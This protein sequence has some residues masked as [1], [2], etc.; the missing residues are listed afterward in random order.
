MS[1]RDSLLKAGVVSQKDVRRLNQTEAADRKKAKAE[2]ENREERERREAEQAK[3]AREEAAAQIIAARRAREREEE[4]AAA[5]R[6]VNHL[7]RDYQ[8][9]TRGGNQPFWHRTPDGRHVHKLMMNDRMAWELVAGRIAVSWTGDPADPSYI[10]LPR[11][12]VDR[13]LELEPSRILFFNAEAPSKDDPS[14][15]LLELG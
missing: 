4:L 5:R 1:L 11:D 8:L 12:A 14:E 3:M 7:I 10:L 2:R 15:R 13:I 9:R 6:R